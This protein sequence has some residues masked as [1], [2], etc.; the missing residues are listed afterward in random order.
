MKALC[1]DITVAKVKGPQPKPPATA[2]AK[3][4]EPAPAPPKAPGAGQGGM[5]LASMVKSLLSGNDPAP[6]PK[7]G[8][9]PA[10]KQRVGP[11]PGEGEAEEGVADDDQ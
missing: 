7:M 5:D 2:K 4:K 1:E 3:A 9:Q 10:K 11:A 8:G 6:A